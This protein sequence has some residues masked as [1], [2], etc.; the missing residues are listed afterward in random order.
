MKIRHVGKITLFINACTI[1][2][3]IAY[4]SST[5]ILL[6]MLYRGTINYSISHQYE[7]KNNR[8]SLLEYQM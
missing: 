1:V 2:D 8:N 7:V 3:G 6:I 5:V 4:R